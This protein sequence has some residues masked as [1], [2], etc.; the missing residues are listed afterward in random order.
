MQT[1]IDKNSVLWD[2]RAYTI[3][4]FTACDLTTLWLGENS[5][6]C[7]FFWVAAA[8]T[9]LNH[10]MIHKQILIKYNVKIKFYFSLS[11]AYWAY[12]CWAIFFS[13]EKFSP[14]CIFC[15]FCLQLSRYTRSIVKLT[16]DRKFIM[17][18]SSV[19]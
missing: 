6:I 9:I 19:W 15:N 3:S 5:Y 1:F 11:F 14:C 18:Q 13:L 2:M 17:L 4:R 10:E 12:L 16:F 7:G 8:A